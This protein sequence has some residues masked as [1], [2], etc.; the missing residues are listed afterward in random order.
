[1]LFLRKQRQVH[2]TDRSLEGYVL[3]KNR[4]IQGQENRNLLIRQF[5]V[6]D[7]TDLYLFHDESKEK[8]KFMVSLSGCFVQEIRNDYFENNVVYTRVVLIIA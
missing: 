7:Y 1:M 2:G 8:L 3:L 6:L 5:L 4:S